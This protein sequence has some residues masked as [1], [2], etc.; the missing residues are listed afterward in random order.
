V[1]SPTEVGAIYGRV[2]WFW[3]GGD[4]LGWNALRIRVAA[5]ILGCWLSICDLRC[6]GDSSRGYNF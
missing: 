3:I 6:A 2:F 4:V 1:K 5:N